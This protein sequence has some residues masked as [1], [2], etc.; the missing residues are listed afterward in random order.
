MKIERFYLKLEKHENLS[1][2]ASHNIPQL[3][4]IKLYFNGKIDWEFTVSF[5]VN[6]LFN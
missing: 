6:E 4:I 2:E 5:I 1:I 3:K